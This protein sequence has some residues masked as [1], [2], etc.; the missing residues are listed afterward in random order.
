VRFQAFEEGL[1]GAWRWHFGGTGTRP[2]RQF[3]VK[4]RFQT[5]MSCS[6][7]RPAKL[8]LMVVFREAFHVRQTDPPAS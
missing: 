6:V 4:V 3:E 7:L 1:V 8:D 5:S 2:N